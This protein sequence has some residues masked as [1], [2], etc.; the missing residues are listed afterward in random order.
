[1][2]SAYKALVV[3]AA[4]LDHAGDRVGKPLLEVTVGLKDVRHEE[5]H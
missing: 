1:M 4:A 2:K 5:V 3:L